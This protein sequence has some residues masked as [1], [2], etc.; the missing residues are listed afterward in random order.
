MK[1]NLLI[2]VI[3]ILVGLVSFYLGQN[4][5]SISDFRGADQHEITPAEARHLIENFEKNPH[6]PQIKG[7]SFN[8]GIVDK[9]LA[10]KDCDGLRFYY[11]QNDTGRAEL[12]ITGITKSGKAMF[13]EVVGD[14]I[15][16]CPPW[17]D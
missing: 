16:P 3:I 5:H 17:C 12:V 9:I 4:Y 15:M 7:G 8:R 10:Q 11:A 13:M 2:L 6:V 14:Q 1:R